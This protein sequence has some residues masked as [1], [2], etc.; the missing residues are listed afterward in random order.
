ME[1]VDKSKIIDQIIGNSPNRLRESYFHTHHR[2]LLFTILEFT[3]NISEIRFPY[4]VWHWVNNQ[5]LY[6]TCSCGVRV[7]ENMNWRLGYKKFCSNKCSS[8]SLET[9]TKLK[10]TNQR[11][12]GVNHYSQTTQYADKVKQTSQ[13]KWGVDNYSK[14]AEFLEKA[15]KT[16][17]KKWGVDSFTKTPEFLEKSKKTS[18]ANW[19]VEFPTQSSIIKEKIKQTNFNRWGVSH[20]F[21]Y[22]E[23]RDSSFKISSH[24][25][26]ISYEEGLNVFMCDSGHAHEFTISTD[27]YYGRTKSGN[28]LCTVCCPISDTSSLKEKEIFEFIESHY[29]GQIIR[30]YRPDKLEIDIYL[31]ELGLGFEFNG[32]WWHSSKYKEKAYHRKKTQH[33][34]DQG[35]RIIHLWEDDWIE[36]S[37]ILKS[38][39]K[40]WL[41]MSRT[42]IFARQCQIVEVA[43]SSDFL[44]ANHLQGPD[45]SSIKIGLLYGTE[46]VSIM[47]F[48]KA[49][50]RKK[51]DSQSWNLS[52]FCN[53]TDH[54]VVGG[55]S[56][57]LSWFLNKYQAGRIVSYADSDWSV[58]NLYH[59]LGFKLLYQTGPDYKYLIN[60]R[61]VHKS[62]YRK[63]N[64]AGSISES[65]HMKGVP[66]IWD[67]GKIKF[68]L[69]K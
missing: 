65:Q 10:E 11:N 13:K 67:C 36:K 6:I 37:S 55:A 43:N 27:D 58:G 41:G 54:N 1:S 3:L 14:T 25:N 61:R 24:S 33:F 47:T 44:G 48:N 39:I 56:K 63:S 12:W 23:Y 16:S 69:I 46:L 31:P 21:E 22:N 8:N 62:R 60:H 18:L 7:S 51:M 28:K 42:K 2:D 45:R 30:G 50:G 59:Q 64:L 20:I 35:I 57:I 34:K 52:R 15:K 17:L 38:Q 4:K 5:P 9:K 49:E 53:K 32:L 19:G 66:K 26:Y 68:E 29:S 40:N